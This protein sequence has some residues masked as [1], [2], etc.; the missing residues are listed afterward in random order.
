MYGWAGKILKIDLSSESFDIDYTA[1]YVNLY[2]GGALLG[3][4]LFSE[5]VPPEIQPFDPRNI[6]LFNTGPLTGTLFGNKGEFCSKT[7]ERSNYPYVH[8]GIGGQFP[9]E[10]KFAGYDH[11]LIRGRASKPVYLYISN[12]D[13]QIRDA[14]HLWG[15]DVWQTQIRIKEEIGDPEV[16]IATIGPAGE[17]M[18]VY[19]LIM[20]DINNTASRKGLG[21]VMGSKNLK[22][23]AVRGKK[24]VKIY[25]PQRALD[26]WNKVYREY[27]PG[28]RAYAFAQ[29]LHREGIS[30]QIA[31]GYAY[32]YG[33][34]VPEKLPPSPIIEFLKKNRVKPIGCAFCP[35]QCHQN[36]SVPGIGNGGVNCVNYFSLPYGKLYEST[37]YYKWFEKTLLCNRYGIDSLIIE[38]IGGWLIDAFEKGIINEMDTNGLHFVK[39]NMEAIR[40]LIEDLAFRRGFAA[41]FANG[42]VEGIERISRD[43]GKDPVE[44]LYMA[45]QYDNQFPYGAVEYA[46]DYGPV[47]RF[48]V[49]EV[50]RVPGFADGY[51]NIPAYAE[52]LGISPKE[53]KQL[54]E[55]FADDA[56]ERITGEK[57]LWRK[58]QY[59]PKLAMLVVEKENEFLLG[60]LTGHCEVQ[61][62]Y[63]DHYGVPF[64][65]SH[66]QEWI[67]AVTGIT[68]SE[69]DLKH[70]AHMLRVA[71]DAYNALCH[72]SIGQPIRMGRPLDKLATFPVPSR[73]K[74]P[75]ELKKL[76]EDYCRLRGYDHQTGIPFPEELERLGFASLA[77]KLKQFIAG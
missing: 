72:L 42:I 51:G 18:V 26:L 38:S 61:S 56:C 69:A 12:N 6:L 4:I 64:T 52:I 21:A 62:A 28:G 55:M 10:V 32:A 3:F 23:I 53:A 20:H 1:K 70:Y 25:D 77:R 43:K 24:G 19:A 30:R 73:P 8:V 65:F 37:D 58:G 67:E 46:P 40:S 2:F 50:E 47:A 33:A 16:Q 9:S 22:A 63:L 54:I 17:N 60:D 75:D 45:D 66:Y 71:L 11:I 13:V 31:E 74:D 34:P 41:L 49:G 27:L 36:L 14:G 29:M 48:R 5:E 7:P 44:L 68:I 39:G 35:I 57:D 59:H 76:Q 15:L